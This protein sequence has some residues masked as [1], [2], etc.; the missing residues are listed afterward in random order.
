MT[1]ELVRKS[2]RSNYLFEEKIVCI[3]QNSNK[4]QSKQVSNLVFRDDI[5]QSEMKGPAA[6]TIL[7]QGRRPGG[8]FDIYINP[9][10]NQGDNY[11][12]RIGV[13]PLYLKTFLRPWNSVSFAKNRSAVFHYFLYLKALI[14]R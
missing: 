1:K 4:Y 3:A 12:N 9:I 14:T 6:R 2:S 13:S 7:P 8:T 11:A 10:S 5:V